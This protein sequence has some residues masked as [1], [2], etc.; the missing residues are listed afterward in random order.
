[1]RHELQVKTDIQSV[2]ECTAKF[3]ADPGELLAVNKLKLFVIAVNQGGRTQIF[4]SNCKFLQKKILFNDR[5]P[6]V[7]AACSTC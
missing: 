3:I 4:R 7:L 2:A 1:M 6:V 5:L